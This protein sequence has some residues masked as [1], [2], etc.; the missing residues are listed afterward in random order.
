MPVARGEAPGI[1]HD[2]FLDCGR[3]TAHSAR[4]LEQAE[5]HGRASNA[6][7]L[8]VAEEIELRATTLATGHRKAISNALRE[9]N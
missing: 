3:I 4:E 8:R 5:D 7:L 9:A 2:C 1:S 6:F